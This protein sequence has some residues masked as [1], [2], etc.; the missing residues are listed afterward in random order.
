MKLTTA[1]RAT[2]CDSAL[3][4]TAYEIGLYARHTEL[5]SAL[6]SCIE[7][8]R[9]V[10]YSSRRAPQALATAGDTVD[11]VIVRT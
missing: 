8:S 11:I 10:G 4:G 2:W 5:R 3:S 9:K 7:R 6:K 1:R